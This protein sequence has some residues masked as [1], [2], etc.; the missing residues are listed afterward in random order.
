MVPAS[1]STR[2]LAKKNRVLVRSEHP[3]SV[4]DA[5]KQIHDSLRAVGECELDEVVSQHLD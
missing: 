4:A 1:E 5:W 3:F 2:T